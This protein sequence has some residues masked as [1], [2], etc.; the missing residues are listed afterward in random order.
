[1]VGDKQRGV[2]PEE[3]F[4]PTTPCE[5]NKLVVNLAAA[6]GLKSVIFDVSAAFFIGE[7]TRREYLR[8]PKFF[9]SVFNNKSDSNKEGVVKVNGNFYGLRQAPKDLVG[10]T[11]SDSERFWP[12][13]ESVVRYHVLQFGRGLY[14]RSSPC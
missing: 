10:E 3:V 11:K 7:I 4:A 9:A 14:Y 12:Q 6:I 8:L 1:M 5:I 2:T 13:G